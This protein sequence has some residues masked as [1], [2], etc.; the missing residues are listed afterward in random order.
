MMDSDEIDKI[1]K[2]YSAAMADYQ[3]VTDA[4]KQFDQDL[5]DG[6]VLDIEAIVQEG[7]VLK[8]QEEAAYK[9]MSR[10]RE[11]YGQLPR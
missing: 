3:A 5:F 9:R 10:V 4:L 11:K 7:L 1:R 6:L 2:E 8:S